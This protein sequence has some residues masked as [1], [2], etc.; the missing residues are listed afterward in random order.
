VQQVQ[1]EVYATQILEMFSFC[2]E[3]Q[4]LQQLAYLLPL[5]RGFRIQA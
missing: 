4:V 3:T 2:T 5:A 1:A